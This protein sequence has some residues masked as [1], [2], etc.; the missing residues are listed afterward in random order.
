MC[1]KNSTIIPLGPE[2]QTPSLLRRAIVLNPEQL[3][4]L[5]NSPPASDDKL[6]ARSKSTSC[7]ECTKAFCL[8]QGISF[9]KDV[10]EDDVTTMCFK[11]DSNKDKI[12]VWGF[13]V[14]TL[15]LL[16]WAAFKRVV[17]LRGGDPLGQVTNYTP[18]QGN[19]R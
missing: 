5:P 3:H 2:S 16:G 10:H 19:F 14:G 18:V 8:G 12:I 11:R 7:S 1:G 9:C 17:E 15:G 4:G 6:S 13:I